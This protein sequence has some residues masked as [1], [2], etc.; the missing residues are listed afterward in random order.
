MVHDKVIQAI[1]R[2]GG[3]ILL[4]GF[5]WMGLAMPTE[6]EFTERSVRTG[7]LLLILLGL[8][9]LGIGVGLVDLHVELIVPHR[10]AVWP[11]TS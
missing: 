2:I 9:M 1:G 8:L 6:Q 3:V 7:P 10:A 5:L 4:F 11:N